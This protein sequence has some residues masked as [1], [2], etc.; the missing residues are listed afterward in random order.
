MEDDGASGSQLQSSIVDTDPPPP[1]PVVSDQQQQ[2]QQP[3]LP[4]AGSGVNTAPS[5]ANGLLDSPIMPDLG[6][7]ASH[8]LQHTAENQQACGDVPLSFRRFLSSGSVPVSGQPAMPAVGSSSS[9]MSTAAGGG[10]VGVSGTSLAATG[11]PDIAAGLPDFVHDDIH[12]HQ[13]TADSATVN[14]VQAASAGDVGGG[15]GLSTAVT[16][17]DIFRPM[18]AN[19]ASQARLSARVAPTPV[20]VGPAQCRR[21]PG[22]SSSAACCSSSGVSVV[23]SQPEAMAGLPDFLS[24]GAVSTGCAG[25]ENS[26]DGGAGDVFASSGFAA[27]YNGRPDRTDVPMLTSRI[28]LLEQENADLRLTIDRLRR[29]LNSETRRSAELEARLRVSDSSTAAAIPAS[30]CSSSDPPPAPRQQTSAQLLTTAVRTESLIR[31]L[32]DSARL[33]REAA[34]M[35]NEDADLQRGDS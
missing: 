3:V 22:A 21:G 20:R 10:Q 29:Q 8:A 31:E 12:D 19:R 14:S 28:A 15:S 1:P 25:A 2:Q 18:R 16:D 32:S 5:A 33:L 17:S 34:S 4:P 13:P 24:D 26:G 30:D 35:L 11:R 23:S 27:R 6:I 9:M 7:P